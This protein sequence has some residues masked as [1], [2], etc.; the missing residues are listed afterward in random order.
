MQWWQR[1]VV[2]V[3]VAD[4]ALSELWTT[5]RVFENKS[6]SSKSVTRANLPLFWLSFQTGAYVSLVA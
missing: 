3:V 2:V 1:G 6:Y 4:A 5:P